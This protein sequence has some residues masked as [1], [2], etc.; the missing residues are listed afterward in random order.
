[1]S[2][3]NFTLWALGNLM[4][5]PPFVICD[6]DDYDAINWLEIPENK[7]PSKDAVL[8]EIERI[9]D[10]VIP[11]MELRMSESSSRQE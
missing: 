8:V 6:V 4:D 3:T 11:D 9:K 7:R 5:T 1:M 2:E 10:V